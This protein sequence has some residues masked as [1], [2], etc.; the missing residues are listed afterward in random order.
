MH[1]QA[2]KICPI[3]GVPTINQTRTRQT[4]LAHQAILVHGDSRLPVRLSDDLSAQIAAPAE[5][6]KR[7]A[8]LGAFLHAFSLWRV[9]ATLQFTQL[10][11]SSG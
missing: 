10:R 11:L 8:P 1:L 6:A 3:D 7:V 9:E 4:A 2:L 5:H